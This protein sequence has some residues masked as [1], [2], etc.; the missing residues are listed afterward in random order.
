MP[1]RPPTSTPPD[2]IGIGE[3]VAFLGVA[4]MTLRR[5]D[6]TRK[7][8]PYPL[9]GYGGCGRKAVLELRGRIDAGAS[10]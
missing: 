9:N 10:A 5:W 2:V 4:E 7:F 1:R 6:K 8:C 3:A